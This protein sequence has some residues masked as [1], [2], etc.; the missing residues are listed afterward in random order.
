MPPQFIHDNTT[1]VI[2]FAMH[3]NLNYIAKF[4]AKSYQYIQIK[5]IP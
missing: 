4:T 2:Q 3:D 5:Q 1:L